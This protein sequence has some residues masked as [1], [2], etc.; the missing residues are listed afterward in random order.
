MRQSFIGFAGCGSRA[1]RQEGLTGA[2]KALFSAAEGRGLSPTP[3]PSQ[4]I[5]ECVGGALCGAE[6]P[7]L[8]ERDTTLFPQR[9]EP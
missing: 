4:Q 6:S 5:D 2:G 1:C 7:A 9:F 8:P 3:T